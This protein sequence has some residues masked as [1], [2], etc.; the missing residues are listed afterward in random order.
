MLLRQSAV[1]MRTEASPGPYATR[2]HTE[3]FEH[4][5][6]C[7]LLDVDWRLTKKRRITDMLYRIQMI[8]SDRDTTRELEPMPWV[9]TVVSPRVYVPAR[10]LQ[11]FKYQLSI[12]I[13]Q[14]NGFT[15][16]DTPP[17]GDVSLLQHPYGP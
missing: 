16:R 14:E 4:N 13:R 17:E 7:N 6:Q 8:F 10:H 11:T 15:S 3:P 1:L 9:W 2:D 5:G 12:A